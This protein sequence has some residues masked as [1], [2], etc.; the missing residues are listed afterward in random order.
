M[1]PTD[2]IARSGPSGTRTPSGAS[3]RFQRSERQ[4]WVTIS[5]PTYAA[6]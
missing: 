1:K 5:R 3:S 2:E 4:M 6:R